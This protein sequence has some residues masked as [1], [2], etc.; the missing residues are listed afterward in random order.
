MKAPAIA[1]ALS[2]LSGHPRIGG[3]YP[4][5]WLPTIQEQ[6]AATVID[7][8]SPRPVMHL[9][10]VQRYKSSMS[11]QVVETETLRAWSSAVLRARQ[12]LAR[13]LQDSRW[14]PGGV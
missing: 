8:A 3:E 10:G 11:S 2:C 1:P 4:R 7:A 12:G 14:L 13:R 5:R 9:G 6:L